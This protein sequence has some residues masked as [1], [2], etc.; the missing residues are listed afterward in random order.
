M[1]AAGNSPGRRSQLLPRKKVDE[2]RLKDGEE[3][4]EEV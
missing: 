4:A 3:E 1:K 2:H